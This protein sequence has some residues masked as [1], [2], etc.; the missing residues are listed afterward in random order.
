MSKPCSPRDRRSRAHRLPASAIT[1]AATMFVMSAARAQMPAP[2]DAP[3][4]SVDRIDRY[5]GIAD[6]ASLRVGSTLSASGYGTKN[7]YGRSLR[8][9]SVGID[10]QTMVT[11]QPR[12]P[13]APRP[14]TRPE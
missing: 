8:A 6:L 9:E 10:G 12:G 14:P 7:A 5:D 13:A 1:L 4:P 2:P 11:L 3:P